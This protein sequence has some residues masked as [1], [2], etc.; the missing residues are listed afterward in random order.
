MQ[1]YHPT[2][3]RDPT[4]IPVTPFSLDLPLGDKQQSWQCLAVLRL[5]PGK[6]LVL[7]LQRGP[8]QVLCKLFFQGSDYQR[9]LRGYQYLADAHIT[10]PALLQNYKM[11]DSPGEVIH[12]TFIP[13][14]NLADLN[15]QQPLTVQS[16]A[17]RATVATVADMHLRGLRQIDIHL[18]NFVYYDE[19]I[20]VVDT[21]AIRK[22]YQPLVKRLAVDNLGDL[23][24][25][26]EPGQIDDLPSICA[27]YRQHFP[28]AGWQDHEL[29]AAIEKNRQRR[30][31]H[32]RK[33]LTRKCS[34][35]N[36]THDFSRVAVWRRS[37]EGDALLNTLQQPDAAL[38]KGTYLKQGNTATVARIDIDGQP[39]IVK[40][41]NIKHWRHRLSRCW[42]PTRA[43]HSW[44]NAHYLL[45]N[46][47]PTP[48]PIA[49]IEERFGP[50]RGRA[51]F[52]CAYQSGEDLKTALE[53]ADRPRRSE[54]LRDF[55]GIVCGYYGAG[56][57]HGDMK[58]DNFIV[59]ATGV[60]I[61]DLDPMQH[62]RQHDSL[63]LALRK[64]IRRFL[65]NFSGAQGAEIADELLAQLPEA[66]QGCTV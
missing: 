5:F 58:A 65:E 56:I 42:R 16:A 47:L 8:Q 51:F 24:A 9:E 20:Y 26:F 6:R 39:V 13:G 57:S 19:K 45:F 17:F 64:D 60:T 48:Q 34:E 2:Q 23:L 59:C 30:W 18:G 43:W 3:L 4:L 63:V 25:Q 38:A 61:I 53:T 32:Y 50:L 44:Q 10:T 41:Y 21:A 22:R 35:F 28:T 36:C 54:L 29:P 62:H 11:H 12:Y 46:G 49:L 15:R 66:L 14:T 52:L 40:R 55:A 27:L 31:R 33:K 1:H 7:Q 37:S